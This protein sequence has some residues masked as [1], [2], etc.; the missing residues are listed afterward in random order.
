MRAIC[1]AVFASPTMT[2]LQEHGSRPAGGC[3]WNRGLAVSAGAVL[4]WRTPWRPTGDDTCWLLWMGS[5]R[6][7]PPPPAGEGAS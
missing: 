4:I 7:G 5:C 1:A 3:C 6:N 2:T